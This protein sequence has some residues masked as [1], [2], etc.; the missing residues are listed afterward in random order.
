MNAPRALLTPARQV[1]PV[2][3]AVDSQAEDGSDCTDILE[4]QRRRLANQLALVP[5]RMLVVVS[6]D[7]LV[8]GYSEFD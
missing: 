3:L 5:G 6:H 7:K 2:Q 4:F 1:A 8:R